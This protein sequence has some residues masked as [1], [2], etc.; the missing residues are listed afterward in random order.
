MNLSSL[1]I[2]ADPSAEYCASFIYSSE[3]CV[4]HAS[5]SDYVF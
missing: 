1:E 5:D 2:S 3:A 4:D